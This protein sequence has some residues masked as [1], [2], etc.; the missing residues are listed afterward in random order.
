LPVT[1]FNYETP[2]WGPLERAIKAAGLPP[3]TAGEFMWMCEQPQGN[4]QYKHCDTR[5]YA[6]LTAELDE[7]AAAARVTFARDDG[8]WGMEPKC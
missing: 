4:H 7:S 2:D 1:V 6:H 3:E 8:R 5:G